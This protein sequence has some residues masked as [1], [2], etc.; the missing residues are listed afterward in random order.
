M[1]HKGLQPKRAEQPEQYR[2]L[3]RCGNRRWWAG[4]YADQPHYL[5]I[6]F[7][8]C[9][10]AERDFDIYLTNIASILGATGGNQDSIRAT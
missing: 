10:A 9:S 8:A 4:G 3:R 6:E 5:M 2:L 7:D 1:R